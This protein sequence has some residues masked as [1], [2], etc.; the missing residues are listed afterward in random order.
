MYPLGYPYA[1]HT[2]I[3]CPHCGQLTHRQVNPVAP[4]FSGPAPAPN[5]FYP[6]SGMDPAMPAMGSQGYQPSPLWPG[7]GVVPHNPPANPSVV[8][9]KEERYARRPWPKGRYD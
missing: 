6:M 8:S 2:T 1:T 7:Q 3:Y 9:L 5:G 4:P